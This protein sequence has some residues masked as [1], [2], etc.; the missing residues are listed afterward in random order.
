MSRSFHMSDY[1]L[2]K[3]ATIHQLTTMLATSKIVL[4]P[5]HSNHA[6]HQYWWP[7]TL[8]ITL[9]KCQVIGTDG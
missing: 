4:F 2:G 9:A 8:I 1:S 3:A 7:F 6:K 5:D